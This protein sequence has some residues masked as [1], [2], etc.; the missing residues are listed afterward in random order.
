MIKEGT[1]SMYS[2]SK[3]VSQSSNVSTVHEVLINIIT[4]LLIH[5]RMLKLHNDIN[6]MYILKYT[7]FTHY[8]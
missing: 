6:I 3:Q 5:V 7:Q 1:W 2:I 8:V 4:Q